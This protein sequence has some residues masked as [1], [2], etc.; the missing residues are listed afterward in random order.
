MSTFSEFSSI[1]S[2]CLENYA[3][4]MIKQEFYREFNKNLEIIGYQK[5]G[6]LFNN[7]SAKS[8]GLPYKKGVGQYQNLRLGAKVKERKVW[9]QSH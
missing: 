7:W 6:G 5:Y 4:F 8:R 9:I 1:L 3:T 2:G